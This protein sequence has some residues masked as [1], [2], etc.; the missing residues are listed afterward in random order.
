[1]LMKRF[2]LLCLVMFLA[3]GANAQSSRISFYN[4]SLIGEDKSFYG[5]YLTMDGTTGTMGYNNGVRKL[6]L[7]SYNKKT[8]KL[9]IKE[10]DSRGRYTGQFSGTYSIEKYYGDLYSEDYSGYYTNN[11]GRKIKFSFCGGC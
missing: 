11:K 3:V 8:G 1:M 2:V 5:L 10:Y 9:I 7:V 6:K 4:G